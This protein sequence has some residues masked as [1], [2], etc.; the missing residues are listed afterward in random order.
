MLLY[1][2]AIC[3]LL[4]ESIQMMKWI[5]LGNFLCL[6]RKTTPPQKKIIL[7]IFQ[8]GKSFTPCW[9]IHETRKQIL[10]P[11]YVSPCLLVEILPFSPVHYFALGYPIWLHEVTFGNSRA[12][13]I[14]LEYKNTMFKYIYTLKCGGKKIYILPNMIFTLPNLCL[15]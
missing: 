8:H 6:L 10:W 1:N 7:W 14:S 2:S 13:A 15:F 5:L 11:V 4:R 3:D 9:K 12:R